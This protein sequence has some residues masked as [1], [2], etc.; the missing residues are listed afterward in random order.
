MNPSMSQQSHL[1]EQ[2][3]FRG[4]DGLES[5]TGR[6]RKTPRV[7]GMYEADEADEADDARV[8]AGKKPRQ[9]EERNMFGTLH[10]SGQKVVAPTGELGLW[11]LFTVSFPLRN[12]ASATKLTTQDICM[13]AEG[14]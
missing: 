10:V 7:E 8:R 14:M 11:F 5:V 1:P 2:T 12:I 9:H 3:K 4:S 6:S 13:K